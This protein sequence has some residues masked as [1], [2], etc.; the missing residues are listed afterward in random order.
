LTKADKTAKNDKLKRDLKK[1]QQELGKILM[2]NRQKKVYQEVEKTQQKKKA[3]A[4]KLIEKK[5]TIDKKK[6]KK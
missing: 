2:S 4:K 1:E 3:V 5:K 6:Q